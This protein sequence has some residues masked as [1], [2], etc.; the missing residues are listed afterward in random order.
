MKV[1]V[2]SDTH[3]DNENYLKVLEQEKDIDVVI[4]CGDVEG[5]EY[6]IEKACNCDAYIVGGNND[7]FSALP[8]ELEIELEGYRI[9]ITHG[10]QYYVSMGPE[11]IKK[12]A[13]AKGVHM[14]IFGHTHKP[15]VEEG[16]NVILL[17][18]GSLTYPRQ[19]GKEPSYITL[20][21]EKS[22]APIIQ[23]HYLKK[24]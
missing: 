11:F 23:I 9:L 17:N 19:Q 2:I 20:F 13:I 5:T 24:N 22:N 18:P 12:E 7:Y 14:V 8:K 10:H 6:A 21:L 3:R 15:L 4:H 16:D 1:L